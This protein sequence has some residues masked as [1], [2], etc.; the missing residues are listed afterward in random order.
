MPRSS[1][2]SKRVG[3]GFAGAVRD[4]HAVLAAFDLAL[5]GAVFLEQAVHD[6]GAARV[7]QEFAMIADQAARRARR[8]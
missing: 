8:R 2:G 7:G 1:S 4:Q 5:V 3:V 6:A